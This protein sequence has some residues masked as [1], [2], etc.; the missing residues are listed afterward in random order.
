MSKDKWLK[1]VV[2][3]ALTATMAAGVSHNEVPT[4][5]PTIGCQVRIL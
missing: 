1:A 5:R 2:A 4:S 3:F